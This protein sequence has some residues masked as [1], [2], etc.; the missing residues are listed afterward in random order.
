MT[1]QQTEKPNHLT[2]WYP[3]MGIMA[4]SLV[5][6]LWVFGSDHFVNPDGVRYIA[7]A[8]QIASGNIGE[9]LKL[10]PMIAFTALLA[11]VHYFIPNWISAAQAINIIALVGASIP[12]YGISRILFGRQAAVWATLCFA[13]TP[14]ANEQVQ[15][16]LRDPAF[17][18]TTMTYVLCM[19]KGLR[20]NSIKQILWALLWAGGSFLF[21]IEGIVFLLVP[22]PFL[23]VKRFMAGNRAEKQ[24]FQRALLI[25]I[26]IPFA[27]LVVVSVILGSK[28]MTLSRLWQFRDELFKI[29]T[30]SAFDN[31]QKIYH[32]FGTLDKHPPFSP[33]AKSLPTLVRHWMPLIYLIGLMEYFIKQ[34]FVIYLLPLLVAVQHYFSNRDHKVT[35]E[36]KFL[37]LVCL[38]YIL[39][40]YYAYLVRDFIQGRF[41]LTP[42]VLLYPWVGHGIAL[43]INKLQGVRFA[44]VMR[45]AL[46]ILMIAPAFGQ[47]AGALMANDNAELEVVRFL[48]HDQKL[49]HAKIMFSD[50]RLW[51]Y[52]PGKTE[53]N[54]MDRAAHLVSK[55]LAKG[56]MTAIEKQ[57]EEYQAEAIILTVKDKNPDRVPELKGYR[58]YRKF[59][60]P[61]GINVIYML[62]TDGITKSR[63]QNQG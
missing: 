38:A 51:V 22:L 59:P 43:L 46:I 16:V 29:V 3:L 18:L 5:L 42:A 11:A 13:L 39:L 6:K 50:Q 31:Y 1:A 27:I 2:P 56:Q 36:K 15:K 10:Y 55:D 41:L 21:R 63:D 61:K 34:L 8:Q 17:L 35:T 48:C 25:W 20:H 37:L 30:F 23:I 62:Q 4:L 53:Y 28:L 40:V 32:F 49:K 7:A 14:Q 60:V 12:L 57:A 45:F 33:Y 24:F 54:E 26:G 58:I 19:L 47:S 9:A 52:C 44:R